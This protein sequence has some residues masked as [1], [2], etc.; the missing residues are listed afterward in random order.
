MQNETDIMECK[1]ITCLCGQR[2]YGFLPGGGCGYLLHP[3]IQAAGETD[4]A[5]A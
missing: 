1:R 2:L 4:R 5:A 3:G